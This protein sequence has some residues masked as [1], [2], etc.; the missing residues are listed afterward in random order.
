MV[1]SKSTFGSF[2]GIPDFGNRMRRIDALKTKESSP[3]TH[4]VGGK[5]KIMM[6]WQ[7]RCEE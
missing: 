1:K 4:A 6:C 7:F 3:D 5:A 2:L